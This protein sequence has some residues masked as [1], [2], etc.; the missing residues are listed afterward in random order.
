MNLVILIGRIS[1]E[2][3]SRYLNDKLVVKFNFAVDRK[4]KSGDKDTDFLRIVCFGKQAEFAEKYL[5]K[6]VKIAITGRIQT[7]SYTNK[8]GVKVYTTDI[9]ADSMEFV[10]RKSVTAN[11]E[12]EVVPGPAT[13]E[14]MNIPD[15][16]EDIIPFK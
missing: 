4:Y 11:D 15:G 3:E 16:I 5:R 6:G 8:D 10:E 12:P 1:S 14:F 9:I 13:G 2:L 7:G